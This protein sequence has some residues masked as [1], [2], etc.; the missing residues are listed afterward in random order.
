MTDVLLALTN[1]PNKP[2]YDGIGENNVLVLD[3]LFLEQG[4]R[5]GS[6]PWSV[7]RLTE[8][9]FSAGRVTWTTRIY[10]NTEDELVAAVKDYFVKLKVTG[11]K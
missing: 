1:F 9:Y 10:A 8:D 3:R 2:I 4:E 6:N 5:M 11:R 7:R